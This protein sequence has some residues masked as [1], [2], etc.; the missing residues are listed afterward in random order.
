MDYDG[1]W[2]NCQLNHWQDEQF[3][4]RDA[5]YYLQDYKVESIWEWDISQGAMNH[6][7]W[8]GLYQQALCA[9]SSGLRSQTT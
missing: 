2:G 7:I 1:S 3:N 9:N 6:F 4:G 5:A 8:I